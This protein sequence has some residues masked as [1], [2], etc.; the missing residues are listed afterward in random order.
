MQAIY[1]LYFK[2][3]NKYYIGKTNRL[4]NRIKEH[5]N[6]LE[7]N[8]HYNHK[9]QKAYNTYGVPEILTL[10]ICE[11]D[12]VFKQECYWIDK[13]K[14]VSNG[15]NQ[16]GETSM[17][18]KYLKH[19]LPLPL[20]DLSINCKVILIDKNNQLHYIQNIAEFCRNN[21]E[22][23][24][25]WKSAAGEISKMI[26]GKTKTYKGYR[27][28]KGLDTITSMLRNSYKIY[29]NNEFIVETNNLAEFCRTNVE[30][31]KNWYLAADNLRKVAS[32]TRKHYL[33][34]TCIRM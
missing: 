2:I 20:P 6:L 33:E 1:G 24:N 22:M 4:K 5:T 28:Y 8:A 18:E 32:G 7:K 27:V 11:D 16:I 17:Q 26:Q 10:E 23:S 12:E 14:S 9:L 25:V 29:K 30:L 15:Y 34:Y 3:P 13:F 21:S 31:S 19:V